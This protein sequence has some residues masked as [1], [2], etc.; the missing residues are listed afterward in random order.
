[1]TALCIHSFFEG[2]ALG[3]SSH[4]NDVVGLI[5]GISL[6]NWAESISIVSL[7]INPREPT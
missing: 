6:H 7:A 1:M 5:I 4:Q 3:V 2:I